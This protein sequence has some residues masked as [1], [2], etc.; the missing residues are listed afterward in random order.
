MMTEVGKQKT[1]GREQ[2]TEGVAVLGWKIENRRQTTESRA[3][4]A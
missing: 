1:E 4:R 2:R 3:L